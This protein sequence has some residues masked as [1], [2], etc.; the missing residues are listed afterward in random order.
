MRNPQRLE[1]ERLLD[2]NMLIHTGSARAHKSFTLLDL[3]HMGNDDPQQ[4]LTKKIRSVISKGRA[5]KRKQTALGRRKRRLRQKNGEDKPGSIY[6]QFIAQV[7]HYLAWVESVVAMAKGLVKTAAFYNDFI[8]DLQI[9]IIVASI[10]QYQFISGIMF[11]FMCCQYILAVNSVKNYFHVCENEHLE[12]I[13]GETL[14]KK[15]AK[16]NDAKSV[17]DGEGSIKSRNY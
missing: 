17:H 9:L 10:V 11:A 7:S 4:D 6:G 1:H 16:P 8:S 3:L 13:F 14:S 2:A 15:I 5:L 12:E